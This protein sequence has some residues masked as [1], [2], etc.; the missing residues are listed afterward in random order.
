M[1]TV[2]HRRSLSPTSIVRSLDDVVL[3]SMALAKATHRG[4]LSRFG[5]DVWDMEPAIFHVTARNAFRTVDFTA[6]VCPVEK[7]MAKEYIYAWLDERPA[8]RETS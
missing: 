1:S 3:K 2:E 8:G 7:L 5:D 6:I 4:S